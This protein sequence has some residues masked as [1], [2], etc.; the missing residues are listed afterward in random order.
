[1]TKPH[2]KAD[3]FRLAQLK[4]ERLRILLIIA[5]VITILA[6]RVLGT[7]LVLNDDSLRIVIEGTVFSA[8]FIGIELLVLRDA[9]RAIKGGPDVPRG[10]WLGSL[11]LE[12]LL[13][14]IALAFLTSTAIEFTYRPLAHAATLW[15]FIIIIL[16]ALRLNPVDCRIA[17]LV[18]AGSYLLAALYLGWRPSLDSKVSILAPERAVISY[19]FAYLIGGFVAGMVAGEIRKHLN[20]ALREAEVKRELDRLA[21]GLQTARNIQQSLLPNSVPDVAGFEIAGWNQPADETG[22]DY[23]DWQPLSDGKFLV[24][25]ADVTGHGIGSALLASVCRAYARA[26]FSVEENLLPAMERINKQ[27]AGDLTN[28]LFVTFVAAIC[29]EGQSCVKLLSA[30][31]GPLFFYVMRDDRFDEKGAQGLPLGISPNFQSEP[32]LNIDLEPGDLIVLTTDGF[33]EWAN[34]A[35]ERFGVERMQGSIRAN[36]HLRPADIISALYQTLFDFSGGTKQQDDLTAVII[37]RRSLPV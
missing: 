13:P 11:I 26:S 3:A 28:G 4:S 18:A 15:F 14:A 34:A 8:I 10:A 5:V 31:H 33:F 36:R 37:K 2:T 29:S 32:E 17:G 25:L 35:G 7:I 12:S 21:H 30:G 27:L 6:F 16:T 1:M 24:V 19:T 22:G 9:Q 20:A 23:Y